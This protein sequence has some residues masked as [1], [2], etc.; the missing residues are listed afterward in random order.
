MEIQILQHI[1]FETD[2]DFNIWFKFQIIV[3]TCDEAQ[4]NKTLKSGVTTYLLQSVKKAV[5]LLNPG[6]FVTKCPLITGWNSSSQFV[7]GEL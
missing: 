2:T 7:K 6:C 5:M 1:I 3:F 4:L